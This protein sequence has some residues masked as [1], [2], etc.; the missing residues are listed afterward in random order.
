L[1][2]RNI[3]LKQ[4]LDALF[5]GHDQGLTLTSEPIDLAA[6]LFSKAR[7]TQYIAREEE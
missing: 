5:I 4:N 3:Q 6:L 7:K 1:T 2:L